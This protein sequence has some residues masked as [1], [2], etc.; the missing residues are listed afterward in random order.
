MNQPDLSCPKCGETMETITADEGG[1]LL[2][3]CP[4]CATLAWNGKDGKV[5]IR[6][7]HDITGEAR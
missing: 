1:S 6:E 7:P 5:E 3:V 2:R 4:V